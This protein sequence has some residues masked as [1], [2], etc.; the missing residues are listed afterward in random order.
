MAP[1]FV[2]LENCVT[3][4]SDSD[5]IRKRL[6]IF[7]HVS[8]WRMCSVLS[9]LCTYL[10]STVQCIQYIYQHNSNTHTH[11]KPSMVYII[12]YLAFAVLILYFS[13][14]VALIV[15]TRHHNCATFHPPLYSRQ[16]TTTKRV[17]VVLLCR[18]ALHQHD[19]DNNT[20]ARCV[21]LYSSSSRAHRNNYYCCAHICPVKQFIYLYYGEYKFHGN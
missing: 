3:A 21:E 6:R 18:V 17:C 7:L 9:I 5:K 15:T 11:K 8:T 2:A 10:H 20:L 4:S 16:Q 19:S 12:V 1:P 14:I 13:I